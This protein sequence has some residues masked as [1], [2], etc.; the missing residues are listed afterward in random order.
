MSQNLPAD[1]FKWVKIKLIA[2]LL[3]KKKNVIH[4]KNLKQALIHRLVF[5]N[6]IE[7]LNFMKKRNQKMTLK[8]IF[9][10]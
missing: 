6:F 1:N 7:S 3:D 2:N 9:S 8:K 4:M 10:S 5:E